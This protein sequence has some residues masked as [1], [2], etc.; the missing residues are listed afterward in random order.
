SDWTIAVRPPVKD[1]S[2]R[3]RSAVWWRST[4]VIGGQGWRSTTVASGEPSLTT[5]GPSLTT[6]GPSVNGG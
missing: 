2:Q 1:G 5:A 4:M 6:T 3:W